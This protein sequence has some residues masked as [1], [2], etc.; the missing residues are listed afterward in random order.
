M[1]VLYK[2]YKVHQGLRPYPVARPEDVYKRQISMFAVASDAIN[3]LGEVPFHCNVAEA[4]W[5]SLFVEESHTL[6][7]RKRWFQEAMGR[8]CSVGLP[9]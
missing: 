5:P 3:V 6:A 9:S 2:V 7:H 1:S 8:L 4:S